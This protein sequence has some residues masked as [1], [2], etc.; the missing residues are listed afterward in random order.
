VRIGNAQKSKVRN[1]V[2]HVFALQK[3]PM[4]LFVRTIGIARAKV[5]IGLAKLGYDI[6]CF[7]FLA[8]KWHRV[9]EAA[10]RPSPTLQST[11]ESRSRPLST[12]LPPGLNQRKSLVL[13]GV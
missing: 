6:R 11:G 13:D 9:N 2:E 8:G 12:R 4:G 3:G 1:A 10:K 5:K 7:V